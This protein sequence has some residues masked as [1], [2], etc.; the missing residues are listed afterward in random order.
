M[1]HLPII[2]RLTFGFL[3]G[4]V[5]SFACRGDNLSAFGDFLPGNPSTN[6]TGEE[7]SPE[8]RDRLTLGE[9][10]LFAANKGNWPEVE[11]LLDLGADP[12]VIE[13]P[14]RLVGPFR[15]FGRRYFRPSALSAAAKAGRID[16]ATRL[17]KLGADVEGVT[18]KVGET[19]LMHA[20][21]AG[22]FEM[23]KFLVEH[24]ADIHKESFGAGRVSDM[25][26][27]SGDERII[28]MFHELLNVPVSERHLPELPYHPEAR[29]RKLKIIPGTDDAVPLHCLLWISSKEL[30]VLHESPRRFSVVNVQ[31]GERRSLDKL[32]ARWAEAE[33]FDPEMLTVSPDGK[34][35]LGFAGTKERP[36]WLATSLDGAAEREWP[37]DTVAT[38]RYISEQQPMSLWLDHR[39]YGEFRK[40]EPNFV[41]VRSLDGGEIH[42]IP[43]TVSDYL[44]D[45]PGSCIALGRTGK[46]HHCGY[47]GYGKDRFVARM[48]TLQMD[49]GAATVS[50]RKVVLPT[51]RFP[52]SFTTSFAVS[53]DHRRIAWVNYFTDSEA[54]AILTSDSNGK[55]MRVEYQHLYKMRDHEEGRAIAPGK[56]NWTP[57]GRA[58]TFWL[59]DKAENGLALLELDKSL[60]NRS[61]TRR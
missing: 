58:L 52:G 6:A 57:D 19:P 4:T 39:R 54:R 7:V 26:W 30:V 41:R 12:N 47:V 20:L 29:S 13:L 46:G 10:L 59:G 34:W 28:R 16:I 14:V 60:E 48:L 38:A 22:Q 17:L 31:T 50:H 32:S 3:L 33:E 11:R 45:H 53:R 43:V 40:G 27:R 8:T 25:A 2:G 56:V 37:R 44:G 21:W 9:D 61:G 24:G 55:G 23:A 35:L 49:Q 5:L 15:S 42:T 36:T 51:E 1:K 18:G